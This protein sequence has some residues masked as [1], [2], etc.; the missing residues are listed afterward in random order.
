MKKFI[1]F[2]AA[3]GLAVPFVAAN[4]VWK[5]SGHANVVRHVAPLA[6]DDTSEEPYIVYGLCSEFE[7]GLGTGSSGVTLSAA[8]GVSEEK[9]QEFK[10]DKVTKV[11]IGFGQSS[12]RNITVF[13][14]K[15]L[16]G[17]PEYSQTALLTKSNDWNEVTL[18]TPYEIDGSQFYIGY[19]LTTRSSSD[20]P[21]GVDGVINT[22]P[23]ADNLGINGE[24]AHYGDQFGAVCIRA[25]ITGENLTEY[26][27]VLRGSTI[28][29]VVQLNTPFQAS[30]YLLNTGWAT[31]KSANVACK[32]NG[33][34]FAPSEVSLLPAEIAPGS[35]GQ[36]VVSGLE[37]DTE[38]AGIPVELSLTELNGVAYTAQNPVSASLLC[39]EKAYARK[40][41]VEEW[42]GNWCGFCPR[43]IVGMEY[44]AESYPDTFIG[45]AVHSASSIGQTSEPM[46]TKSYLQFLN[47]YCDGFPGCIVN[48]NTSLV[49]DPLID[50]LLYAY[51][52]VTQNPAIAEVGLDAYYYDDDPDNI[53]V[54]ASSVFSLSSTAANYKLAFVITEDGVGPYSQ[55]NYYAGGG[56]GPMG[57]WEDKGSRVST[58]FDHVA[59]DI[60]TV[61]G[62]NNSVP[63]AIEKGKKYVYSAALPTTNVGDITKC[64]VVALLLNTSD[65]RIENAAKASLV[66]LSG[67]SDASAEA[68]AVAIEAREGEVVI[69]GEYAICNVY[70]LEGKAVCSVSNETSVA[71]PAGI[72]IVNV[73]GLDNAVTTKKV[74]VK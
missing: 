32:V 18:S 17:E 11:R 16:D 19:K 37:C 60:M 29:E 74:V 67:I 35:F 1:L 27:V 13:I 33:K 46:Y 8:M 31:I 43:G 14:T 34:D 20:Y 25:V 42:T 23:L 69:N 72:Y 4:N 57:G 38:G 7:E 70:S 71:L 55:A 26:D 45:I 53:H 12:N 63:S 50:N 59:R 39:I 58:Y 47:R 41:V 40:V 62:I 65:G 5:S 64:H 56:Y 44:M 51:D 2:I 54:D 61:W 52:I 21:L 49:V 66:H 6:A 24:W 48:R 30:I 73:I 3:I 9:A 15:D 22:N 28:P 10:G 36:I 68:P